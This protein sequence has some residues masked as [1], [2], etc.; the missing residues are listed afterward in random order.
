MLP[1]Y[2]RNASIVAHYAATL[3]P[4]RRAFDPIKRS[5]ASRAKSMA[6]DTKTI[7]S[8]GYRVVGTRP[9]R[10]DGVDKVTGRAK[11]GADYAF[12]RM[13][14]ANAAQSPCTREDQVHQF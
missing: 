4:Q 6:E 8:P 3:L 9:I 1:R 14:H 2:E 11:Y 7:P 5:R 12:P 10:H 13:I